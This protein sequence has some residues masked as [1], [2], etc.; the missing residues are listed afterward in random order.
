[1]NDSVLSTGNW[2][3]KKSGE[4]Q[5]YMISL[6]IMMLCLRPLIFANRWIACDAVLIIL[7]VWQLIDTYRKMKRENKTLYEGGIQSCEKLIFFLEEFFS[8]LEALF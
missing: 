1:M 7:L 4:E 8:L 5:M 3:Q 2:M 6:V